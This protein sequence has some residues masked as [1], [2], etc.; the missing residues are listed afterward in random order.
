MSPSPEQ[1]TASGPP[2]RR[3]LVV[4]DE[5][6]LRL[7]FSYALSSRATQVDTASTGRQALEKLNNAAYDLLILDLRMPDIDGLGVIEILRQAGNTVPIVLCSAALTPLAV[8][9]AIQHR[10]PDFLLKPVRPVDLREVVDYVL[11]PPDTPVSRTVAAIRRGNVPA[12]LNHAQ[13]DPSHNHG[14]TVWVKV[15][16]Y[17]LHPPDD[18]SAGA[19]EGLIRSS[20]AALAFRSTIA[21]A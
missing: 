6:T 4:D 13:S 7:G 9:R 18:D 14:T 20:L 11:A 3:L 5:P 8:L 2:Q 1:Q 12:A 17:V 16:E 21:Q 19:G 15:L 10:V